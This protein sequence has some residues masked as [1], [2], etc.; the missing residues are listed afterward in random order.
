M[1]PDLIIN[2][3]PAKGLLNVIIDRYNFEAK[4]K[5]GESAEEF[6][7]RLQNELD[8]QNIPVEII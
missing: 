6:K 1:E 4:Q 5:E 8:S 2:I 3:K 7:K